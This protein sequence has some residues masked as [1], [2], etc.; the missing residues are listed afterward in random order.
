[1]AENG[2]VG[3]EQLGSFKPDM[4]LLDMLMPVMNGLEFLK[5]A[6]DKIKVLKPKV[7]LLSNLSDPITI[8]NAHVYG[9]D[10]MILKAEL[11]PAELAGV[12]KEMLQTK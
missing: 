5:A 6:K 10:R 7:L 12:I 2:Q 4:V 8:D 9:V 1:L 11:S 3:V